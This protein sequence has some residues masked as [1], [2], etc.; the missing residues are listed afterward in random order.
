MISEEIKSKIGRLITDATDSDAAEGLRSDLFDRYMG[1]PYTEEGLAPVKGRSQ[2]LDTTASDAVEAILP[3]IMDVFTSAERIMDVDPV[4]PEDELPAEQEGDIMSHL[5]WQKNDGF[6]TLYTWIKEALVQQNSYVW[7]GWV[8]KERVTVEEY[9]DLTDVELMG[10]IQSLDGEYEFIEQSGFE[11][12]KDDNGEEYSIQEYDENGKPKPISVKIRCV[13]E[14]KEYLVEPFPQ[15]EYFGTPRWNKVGLTG[16]PCCGRMHDMEP[17]ELLAMGFSQE[18]IDK[19]GQDGTDD[20]Q[21][22]GRH[23]TQ[24]STEQEGDSDKVKVYETYARVD[25]NGKGR[26]CLVKAWM[27]GDG[28]ECLQWADGSDAIDEVSH[29]QIS[30]L[31]PYIIPHR[32]IGR[33]MVELVDGIQQ[34]KTVLMRH[35]LD[36]TYLTNFARPSFDENDAGEHT[37]ADLA[38]PNPGSPIR[39][40]GAEITWTS[41]PSVAGT[42]LPLLDKFDDL[43]E[44]RTGATRYNQGLDADSLNKT[45]GGMKMI[46]NASQKKTKLIARTLA[47][48]GIR[49]LFLRMHAD[50]RAGPVKSLAVKLRGGWVDVDP[51]TWK[52]RTD[53][54]VSIGMGRGDAE[55]VRAG[56]GMLG[57]VQRE[58]KASGSRMVTDQHIYETIKTV[59]GTFG[60][61]HIDKYIADPSTLP[62]PQPV[63]PQPDPVMESV[64]IQGQ[65]VQMDGQRDQQKNQLAAQKQEL[66]AQKLRLEEMKLSNDIQDS[67]E[68][69]DLKRKIAVMEDDF[70]RDKLEIE[71]ATGYMRDASRAVNSA[72]P[73]DY[74]DVTG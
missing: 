1:E 28:S 65:K 72:P 12:I 18:S 69:L 49:D 5:F 68:E 55:E 51:R 62:P 30:A 45:M 44:Q 8:E 22:A 3:D 2:F 64:K 61:K 15:E 32:H 36:S 71:A 63:A 7:S 74:S 56:L 24:D 14:T 29:V 66:E 47:E 23:E 41:P 46:M 38:N 40:G 21:T 17:E 25:L 39:T 11:T 33:S 37:Y 34:V 60:I 42:V 70:K 19:A 20:E 53:M 43:A 16:I 35:M 50:L 52:H 57:Q 9:E 10:I 67:E 31:T 48:T 54:T 4:G 13:K 27:H 58:L 6:T 59:A 73:L 26:L